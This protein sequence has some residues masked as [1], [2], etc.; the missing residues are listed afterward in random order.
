MDEEHILDV[1]SSI[2]V[3]P[4]GKTAECPNPECGKRHGVYKDTRY[5]VC[6][7]C[8]TVFVDKKFDEREDEE[9]LEPGTK[10]ED[11]EVDT[12]EDSRKQPDI[13]SAMDW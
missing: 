1:T 3:Y 8:S 10:P 12:E 11:V 4:N 2:L 6:H 5:I 7:F 13:S 9:P